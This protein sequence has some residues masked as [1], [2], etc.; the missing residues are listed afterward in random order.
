MKR[1]MIAASLFLAAGL[2]PGTIEAQKK[3]IPATRL[4]PAQQAP[5]TLSV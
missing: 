2:L 3:S 4:T 5:N 1:L